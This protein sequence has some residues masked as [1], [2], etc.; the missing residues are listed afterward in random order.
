[1]NRS[2][3]GW[4]AVTRMKLLQFNDEFGS[5]PYG[6]Q[7]DS[8]NWAGV[9]ATVL[10]WRR[11]GFRRKRLNRRK[12]PAA[13]KAVD[14]GSIPIPASRC[15]RHVSGQRLT[16]PTTGSRPTSGSPAIPTGWTGVAADEVYTF[17]EWRRLGNNENAG[18]SPPRAAVPFSAQ[19]DR[20]HHERRYTAATIST[21][22]R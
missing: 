5:E 2:N 3:V 4:F 13:C 19:S 21:A 17:A 11:G 22:R 8:A 10:G 14:A 15:H 9:E 12:A 7:V 18:R 16:R 6:R 20:L 1:M